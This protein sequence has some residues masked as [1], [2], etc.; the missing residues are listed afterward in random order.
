[1]PAQKTKKCAHPACN[2]QVEEGKKYCSDYCHDSG[3]SIEIACN[4]HHAE[5]EAG[6]VQ[7]A[8]S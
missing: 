3:K 7:T 2:C 6:A 8:A 4:C 1:M 5:C